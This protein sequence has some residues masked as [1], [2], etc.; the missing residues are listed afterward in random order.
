MRGSEHRHRRRLQIGAG[1]EPL[2]VPSC[3]RKCVGGFE[4][5]ERVAARS[6]G[7]EEAG[8]AG[9][10]VPARDAVQARMQTAY[11]TQD[12]LPPPPGESVAKPSQVSRRGGVMLFV[13]FTVFGVTGVVDQDGTPARFVP[14][15]Q[16]LVEG[17]QA[18]FCYPVS[19]G[20]A[21][22]RYEGQTATRVVPANKLAALP[23]STQ[24]AN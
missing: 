10:Q 1:D 16:V 6:S 21:V 14:G 4:A 20:A 9:E 17:R 22:I 11:V 5:G 7:Q 24:T 2:D 8:G 19:A 12:R 18:T 3:S 15:Q 23:P 13:R